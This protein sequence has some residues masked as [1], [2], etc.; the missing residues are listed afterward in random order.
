MEIALYP[1][2][3]LYL[4]TRVYAWINIWKYN[5]DL[6]FEVHKWYDDAVLG[7]YIIVHVSSIWMSLD[8]LLLMQRIVCWAIQMSMNIQMSRY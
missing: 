3:A 8:S 7:K 4:I 2:V 6:D 5:V 1:N